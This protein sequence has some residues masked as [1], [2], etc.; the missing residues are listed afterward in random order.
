MDTVLMA[1]RSAKQALLKLTEKHVEQGSFHELKVAPGYYTITADQGRW[2]GSLH[3]SLVPP[4]P[5]GPP[6]AAL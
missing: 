1:P 5:L 2:A 3:R 4:T 6:P